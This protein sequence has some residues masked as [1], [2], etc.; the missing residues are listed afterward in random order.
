MTSPNLFA[1]G[2]AHPLVWLFVVLRSNPIP[3]LSPA[4]PV[5]LPA[6]PRN[7]AP[8][9]DLSRRASST[10]ARYLPARGV[11]K[12]KTTVRTVKIAN[13]KSAV[14]VVERF[15]GSR[16]SPAPGDA[17]GMTRSLSKGQLPSK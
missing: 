1:S 16:R 9:R 14:D 6:R 4:P 7:H 3:G 8:C 10:H 17:A 15:D 12:H 5:H 11:K 13:V 2:T